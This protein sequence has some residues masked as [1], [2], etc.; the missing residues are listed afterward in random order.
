MCARTAISSRR[1]PGVLRLDPEGIPTSSGR[2]R[3][4]R[5]R[6]NAPSSCLSIPPVCPLGGRGPWY[7]LCLDTDPGSR[8]RGGMTNDI[9]ATPIGL[10]TGKVVFIT[11]ASRGIGAAAARLFAR[12]GAAVVL[13]SR[14]AGALDQVVAEVRADGGCRRRGCPGPRRPREH[15]GGGRSGGEA[16][17]PAGRRVHT[18]AR[19][20]SSPAR[21]TARAR[22]TSTSSSR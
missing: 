4:R 19:R 15:P 14:S 2:S 21:S 16:A 12:E 1:S 7:R 6:R 5:L 13:A 8:E 3:S 9:H 20:S 11:G 18:T 22:R 10:L 17:R